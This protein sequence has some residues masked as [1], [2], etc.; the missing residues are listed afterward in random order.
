M[1]ALTVRSRRQKVVAAGF[2][3]SFMLALGYCVNALH[4]PAATVAAQPAAVIQIAP[5]SIR[6]AVWTAPAPVHPVRARPLADHVRRVAYRIPS[7]PKTTAHAAAGSTSDQAHGAGRSTA[8]S[9]TSGYFE[10]SY[11]YSVLSQLNA[12]RAAHGRPAL[13][14]NSELIAS[15]HAHNL[16]MARADQMSHQLPGE[17]YFADRISAAGYHYRN[18]GE[19][20]GWNSAV[21]RSGALA[22]ESEMYAEGPP[23]DGSVNHYWNIVSRNY[24][25][26]G[27]EV[28]IDTVH[29]TLWL[30]EDFGSR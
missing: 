15:A 27:I 14:M 6:P 17:A 13:T 3:V 19:N 18:A 23:S 29:H 1:A 8:S 12:E 26:V 5:A 20:I 11:A 16:A 10:Q 30:T 4:G 28:W 25:N 22:L 7:A 2:A 21:S 24:T 9:T